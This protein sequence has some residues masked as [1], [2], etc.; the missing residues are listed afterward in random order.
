MW[1]MKS[2]KK[3]QIHLSN[4]LSRPRDMLGKNGNEVRYVL[5]VKAVSNFEEKEV[6][7]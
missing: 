5:L 1:G 2:H 6:N 7:R 3:D 4:H